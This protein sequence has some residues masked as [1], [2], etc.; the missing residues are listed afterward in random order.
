MGEYGA[1]QRTRMVVLGRW[2]VAKIH[3]EYEF[4][5]GL[6]TSKGRSKGG[7]FPPVSVN[8]AERPPSPT[9][10]ARAGRS[11]D[12]SGAAGRS[13]SAAVGQAAEAHLAG[14]G[15]RAHEEVVVELMPDHLAL[16][17]RARHD[18]P[19]HLALRVLARHHLALPHQAAVF[20]YL[21]SLQRG[22]QAK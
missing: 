7:A 1:L 13:A 10:S 3:A 9:S 5:P 2:K 15:P 22:T 8:A 18:V 20:V 19:H 17:V 6:S 11:S 14:D 21:R 16:G 12:G 4:P